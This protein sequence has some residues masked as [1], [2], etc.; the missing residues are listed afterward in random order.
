M[1]QRSDL[2]SDIPATRS[3]PQGGLGSYSWGYRAEGEQGWSSRQSQHMKQIWRIT[4]RQRHPT[5]RQNKKEVDVPTGSSKLIVVLKIIVKSYENDL[6]VLK[7]IHL[8]R[9]RSP[10]LHINA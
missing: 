4:G 1:N 6:T 9:T 2:F 8:H 5:P 7:S 10:S 3:L